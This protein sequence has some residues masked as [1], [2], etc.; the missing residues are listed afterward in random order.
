MLCADKVFGVVDPVVGAVEVCDAG[1]PLGEA[2]VQNIG[3]VPSGIDP[4][5]VNVDAVFL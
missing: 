1:T 3:P 4:G 5:V 2:A